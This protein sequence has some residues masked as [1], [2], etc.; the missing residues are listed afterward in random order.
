M[1]LQAGYAELKIQKKYVSKAGH[2]H[3]DLS[4]HSEDA[5]PFSTSVH[6]KLQSSV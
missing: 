5:T 2:G 1:N 6:A 4:C 3:L